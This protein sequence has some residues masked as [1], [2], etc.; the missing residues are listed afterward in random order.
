M[1]I[2]IGKKQAKSSGFGPEKVYAHKAS[3]ET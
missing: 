2:Q 3:L 1:G